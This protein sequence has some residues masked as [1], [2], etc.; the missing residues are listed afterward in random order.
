MFMSALRRL[1]AWLVLSSLIVL[2]AGA[3]VDA[4]H[5]S[6]TDDS[7]CLGPLAIAGT[8]HADGPQFENT[9]PAPPLEHCAFCHLQRA[10]SNAHPGSLSS[11]VLPP[12]SAALAAEQATV[13]ASG[14][15]PGFSPRGPP[16]VSA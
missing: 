14:V 16:A 3:I 6:M 11:I 2:Q 10:F 13:L 12:L 5:D 15:H 9:L 8:H 1:A 4:R 7:A